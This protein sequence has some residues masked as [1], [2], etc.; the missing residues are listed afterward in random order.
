MRCPHC[1]MSFHDEHSFD[2][3]TDDCQGRWQSD[4]TIC[5]DCKRATI[6]VRVGTVKTHGYNRFFGEEEG[7]W[8]AWPRSAVRLVPQEVSE[9][10]ANLYRQ[11]SAV[12]ADSPMASAALSRRC[13]QQVL[14]VK[15]GIKKKDLATEVDEFIN[16]SG[17]PSYL[18]MTVDAIRHYGN[19]SAHPIENAATGAVI[20]VEDGEAEWLLDILDALFD[21]YFV[22]PA[23]VSAKAQALNA[24]LQQAKKPDMKQ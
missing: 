21:F 10:Y 17:A 4:S 12:L 13:L 3:I 5:P 14:H 23:V 8:M 9:E 24:K 7:R 15:A 22:Q 11:A 18:T 19:F 6:W 20:E 16:N 1:G 2:D